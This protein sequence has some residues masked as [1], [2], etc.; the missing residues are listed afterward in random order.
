M[1]KQPL[2]CGYQIGQWYFSCHDNQLTVGEKL[3]EL[4]DC[5]AQILSILITQFPEPISSDYLLEQV[6]ADY[7]L[8][9]NKLYQHIDS[10]QK[11]YSLV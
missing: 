8:N 2:P 1:N 11:I 3:V 9:R 6:S 4:S 7:E 10:D 5:Q